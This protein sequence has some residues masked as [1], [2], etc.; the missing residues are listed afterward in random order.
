MRNKGRGKTMPTTLRMRSVLTLLVLFLLVGVPVFAQMETATLSGIIQDP[1]GRVVPDVEVTAT[2][3]ETGTAVTTKTNGAGIYFFTGLMPG[4]Y[5]LMVRKPG[6]KEIAIKEFQLYVQDKLEQNFSL[7]IGSVSETMTVSGTN[8]LVN[9]TDGSVS[10]VTEREFVEN[11]PLN[12]QSFNT[13]MLLTPGTVIVPTST[14]SN[15]GQFSINGQRTDGNY[16]Q[17]DGVGANFGASTQSAVGQSGGG[18]TQA[19]NAYGGTASLV[20]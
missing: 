17:V 12:G 3:I 20:S 19:F 7:E 15:P 16:F 2:R 9:T 1:N 11:I 10:T 13:L 6:F 5:H 14:P 18:G 8:P 4:H